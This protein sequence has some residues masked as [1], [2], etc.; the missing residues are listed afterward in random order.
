MNIK[1]NIRIAAVA[2]IACAGLS[3]AIS[4]P[5][6]AYTPLTKLSSGP[7]KPTVRMTWKECY[8]KSYAAARDRGQSIESSTNEADLTCGK[9]QDEY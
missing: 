1:N 7:V 2:A 6:M 3:T 8:T 5:A 9:T 4:T